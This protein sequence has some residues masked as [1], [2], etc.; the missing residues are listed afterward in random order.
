[1]INIFL[2]IRFTVQKMK[3]SFKDCFS[4]CLRI[5]WSHLLKK[6]LMENF[7]LRSDWYFLKISRSV[8]RTP[9]NLSLREECP[10][11]E[12][13]LVRIFL[14]SDWIRTRNNSASGHFSRS[15]LKWKTLQS[16]A[17]KFCWFYIFAG[18]FV[19]LLTSWEWS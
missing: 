3:V 12:L 1:M 7:I 16:L 18:V 5:I 4:K 19:T 6:S 15:D 17:I 13:F 11:T 14:Y 10:N 8:A 9:A 2:S